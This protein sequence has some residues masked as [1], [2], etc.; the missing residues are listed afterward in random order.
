MTKKQKELELFKV[1]HKLLII[2]HNDKFKVIPIINNISYTVWLLSNIYSFTTI[3]IVQ[4]GHMDINKVCP[5]FST[6]NDVNI[7]KK[8]CEDNNIIFTFIAKPSIPPVIPY[9]LLYNKDGSDN[10]NI[11][12]EP[13]EI[14]MLRCNLE[15]GQ[16]CIKNEYITSK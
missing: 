7:L 16:E 11:L 14:A 12:F 2:N 13:D 8:V 6:I 9:D 10:F 5:P 4:G 3:A 1:T 15:N